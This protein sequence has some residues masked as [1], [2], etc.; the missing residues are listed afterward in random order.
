[1]PVKQASPPES[2]SERKVRRE[3][4][5]WSILCRLDD[6]R[7]DTMVD[8]LLLTFIQAV[9]PD[10]TIRELRRELD[11]L[12]DQNLLTIANAGDRWHLKLTYQGVNVIEYATPCPAGIARPIQLDV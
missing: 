7:P 3:G 11:Y 8:L 2:F 9:R 6:S 10:A 5:R 4:M 1:V 12:A